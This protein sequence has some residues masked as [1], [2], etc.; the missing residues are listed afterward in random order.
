[1][2]IIQSH[3][4]LLGVYWGIDELKVFSDSLVLHFLPFSPF[5]VI[6]LDICL[7]ACN[8]EVEKLRRLVNANN[9]NDLVDGAPILYWAYLF[10]TW[11]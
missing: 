3:A 1:V 2:T 10:E 8:G 9:V 5:Q 4:R 6:L 7:A 11:C